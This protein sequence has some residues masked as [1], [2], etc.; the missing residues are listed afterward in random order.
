M[1]ESDRV[2]SRLGSLEVYLRGL[3]EKKDC[4]RAEYLSDRDLQDIVERR[5]EKAIQAAIDIASH[6]IAAEGYG[7]PDNYGHLFR[8][9][10][11]E[12]VL[13]N[14]TVERMVEMAG[15]RNVLAHEYADIV[16]EQVYEQLQDIDHFRA[17]ATE[18]DAAVAE[19]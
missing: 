11:Q 5:F 14:E 1:V 17:F 7:E 16:D 13:T 6:I 8:I 12:D 4:T 2:R 19:T 3:E 15:F 10:E 18:I 9:L